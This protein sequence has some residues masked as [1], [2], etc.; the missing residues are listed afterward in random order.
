MNLKTISR[1]LAAVCLSLSLTAAAT[2]PANASCK[3]FGAIGVLAGA[4]IGLVSTLVVSGIGGAVSASKHDDVDGGTV[5]A[6]GLGA[7]LGAVITSAVILGVDCPSGTVA[8]PAVASLLASTL[9]MV[10]FVELRERPTLIEGA[11]SAKPRPRM[12]GVSL[13][14]DF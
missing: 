5:F 1:I 13:R 7:G 3:D 6:V 8:I 4:G 10:L 2:K 9:A 14:M 12:R 11:T